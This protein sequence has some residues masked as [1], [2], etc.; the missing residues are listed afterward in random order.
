M[1]I[2]GIGIVTA[3]GA[4]AV[5]IGT[6]I[7]TAQPDDGEG[8]PITGEALTKASQAALAFTGGGT[9]TAT[10][11]GDEESLY[12]VEVTKADGSQVDVQLDENF[13]V[14]GD[15]TD[16]PG[17]DIE[18]DA[19]TATRA[20]GMTVGRGSSPP[21]SCSAWPS[22]SPRRAVTSPRPPRSGPADC[23]KVV[24]ESGQTTDECLPISPDSDRVDLADADVQQS[25]VDHEPAAPDKRGHAGDHGRSSRRQA[26]SDR[27][28]PVARDEADRVATARPSTRRS[29][30]TSRTRTDASTRWPSTGTRRPTTARCGTSA[31]T[32]STY[33][34]GKVADTKGTWIANDQTPA[35]MIMPAKPAVGNVYRPENRRESCSR[36][37]ASR[38]STRRSPARA[39]TSAAQSKSASCTWTARARARSSRPATGSSPPEAQAGD[40]EAVSLASPTDSR[41]GPAPAE[42][43]CA[44]RRRRRGSSR[45]PRARTPKRAEASRSDTR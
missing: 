27:S 33:E 42:F 2:K 36:R 37:C 13:V 22:P 19:A 7:A 44:V 31:R 9:V 15:K 14:V 43:A 32:S 28:E 20:P 38:R 23:I 12:E 18:P 40:L 16:P 39:E 3:I 10:E 6:G 29:A 25:H 41:Q 45:R 17:A 21:C 34:D 35:A 1:K 26:V 8:T 5:A 11:V 4:A 24:D 30:S